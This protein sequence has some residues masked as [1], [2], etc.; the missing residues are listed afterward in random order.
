MSNFRT[1]ADLLDG[2]LRRCGEITSDQGT[3]PRQGAALLYLNQIHHNLV[4]GGCE[5]E[6]DVDEPWVW[7][8]ARH[9]IIIQLNPALT[10]GTCA[11]TYGST[12]ATFSVAPQLQSA[13]VSVEG[14]HIKPDGCPEVYRIVSHSSGSTSFSLD[15]PFPQ[16][17]N[18]AQ[19]FRMFQLDYDLIAAA[20]VVDKENDTL[21]FIE[22]G[23]TVLTATVTH[24]SYSPA[25]LATAVAA[26]LN[27][28]GTHGNTYSA[29]YDVNQRLFTV[30]SALNGSGSPIFTLKNTTG[31]TY[32][33]GWTMLGYDVTDQTGAGSYVATYANSTVIRLTQPGRIFF[34]SNLFWGQSSGLVALLD[35][36]AFD[37]QFPLINVRSGAPDSFTV[38]RERN[39]GT[40]TVRFNKYPMLTTAVQGIR[41]EFPHIAVPR[42]LFNNTSSIPLIPRK[43]SRVLEY[44]SSYYVLNDKSDFQKAGTYLGIA[45]KTLESMVKTN[46]KELEKASLN[47]GNIIARPDL[48]PSMRRMRQNDYGYSSDGT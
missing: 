5:L 38:I 19:T 4:M 47:F 37:K 33:S 25:A 31:N 34:G 23:T 16:A 29:S 32:R 13:N 15:A 39:N 35:P 9:P 6:T 8:T 48:M 36:V 18:A 24:G 14:W 17:T 30:T 26:A 43:F 21:D 46:R 44:G 3:S 20:L 1:T 42:D 7:A 45:Q 40:L 22:S 41:V 2:V 10:T 28:A 12:S 11:F 27:A